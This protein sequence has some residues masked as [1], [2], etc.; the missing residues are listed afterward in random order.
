MHSTSGMDAHSDLAIQ[1]NAITRKKGSNRTPADEAKLMQL[2]CLAGLY[3]D[4]QERPTLPPH[5]IRSCIEGGA[6]KLKEGS[7]MR[8]GLFVQRTDKFEY[9]KKLYG[10]SLEDLSKKTRFTTDVRVSRARIM[11][12][13][14]KF[15]K[16]SV[17][18]SVE[19]DDDLIDRA[20]LERW[21]EIA[22]RRVGIG[23]WRPACSGTFGMFRIDHVKEVR[24]VVK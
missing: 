5:V 2:E 10:T 15:D 11:R 13:R 6:R 12:T 18:F 23:D 4:A 9:D 19:G 20:R 3:L 7:Q 1:R 16:W 21:L 24:K 8:E 17:T 22:G 14:P